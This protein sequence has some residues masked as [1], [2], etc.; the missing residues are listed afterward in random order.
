MNLGYLRLSSKASLNADTTAVGCAA[1]R[2]L[3]ACRPLLRTGGA[4][5][6]VARPGSLG[7]DNSGG[8]DGHE[9]EDGEE[10][11]KLHFDDGLWA[12]LKVLCV[13]LLSRC[14]GRPL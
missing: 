5:R 10:A 8:S 1:R 11:G 12:D 3:D 7:Q 2:E 14:L 13:F 6:E 9:G 4:A